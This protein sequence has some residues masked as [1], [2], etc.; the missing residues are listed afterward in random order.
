LHGFTLGLPE[1]EFQLAG[2][3]ISVD[4]L[5]P[6]RLLTCTE[7]VDKAPVFFRRQAGDRGLDLLNPVHT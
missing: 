5:V 3:G 1:Q 7:P 6:A 2:G 4:L